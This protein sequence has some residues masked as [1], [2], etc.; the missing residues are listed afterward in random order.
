MRPEHPFS[1][2]VDFSGKKHN[3]YCIN[4]NNNKHLR[5]LPTPPYLLSNLSIIRRSR[6]INFH[7]CAFS[8]KL[9]LEI[10]LELSSLID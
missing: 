1:V 4:M 7:V 8:F 9:V 2:G 3:N 10:F 6:V 5:K